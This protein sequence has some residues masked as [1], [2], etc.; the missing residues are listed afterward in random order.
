M[1]HQQASASPAATCL[2]SLQKLDSPGFHSWMANNISIPDPIITNTI[3]VYRSTVPLIGYDQAVA[4]FYK[5]VAPS[6]ANQV[7]AS[8]GNKIEIGVSNE[9]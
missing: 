3:I 5:N 8:S 9:N 4:W 6:G 2:A 1:A 7:L